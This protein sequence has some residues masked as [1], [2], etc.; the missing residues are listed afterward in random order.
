MKDL[1]KASMV[2]FD[3]LVFALSFLSMALC[4]FLLSGQA[5]NPRPKN[6]P[7]ILSEFIFTKA[8]FQQC[9]ASTLV[10]L[11]NGDLLAAWFGGEREGHESV[12]IWGARRR[13]GSWSPPEELAREPGTPCW[14]PVLFRDRRDTIWLFYK[15]GPSPQAWTG[16][17]RTS[18]DGRAWSQAT[19]LPAGLLGP[20]KNKP[21]ILSNGD[22]VAGTSVESHRAWAAWVEISSDQGRTWS[23]YGPITV[24]GQNYGII[25]P[26][27]WE[28][29]PGHL[30]MLVRATKQ[31]GYLCEASSNDAGRTWSPAKPTAL[32]NPN[33]GIDAV[34][35]KDGTI[36]LVYN[37]TNGGRTPL[38]IA[39][40]IDDPP[41][42][43]DDAI[44]WSAPLVLENEPGE[45]SYPA[46]IQTKDDMLHISY[47]WRRRRIK[48][49]VIDPKAISS[50][51]ARSR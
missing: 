5:Q 31:I 47:T 49:V 6:V 2:G 36:A 43:I 20:I 44:S 26:T 22:I 15:V 39:F 46:I 4:A 7:S 45:Y 3:H 33:S 17:Y 41:R 13:G 35:T 8:P 42:R 37:H 1:S 9:H 27:L 38:N 16:A 14:N 32:P 18:S 28:G 29:K 12:A 10:E 40:S 19:Y 34:R 23:K 21:I 25:Q 48:H 50:A 24:P 11:P 30:K 51:A